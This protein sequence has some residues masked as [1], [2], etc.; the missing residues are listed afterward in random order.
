M[1][2]SLKSAKLEL[3]VKDFSNETH[4]STFPPGLNFAFQYYFNNVFEVQQNELSS[5]AYEITIKVKVPGKDDGLFITGNQLSL[6]NWNPSQI[7]M[8]KK[9][10]FE[11]EL[12]VKVHSPAQFKFTKGDW[13]TEAAVKNGSMQNITIIPEDNKEYHFEI[14]GFNQ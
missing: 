4:W 6:G 2:D 13:E 9:S 14:T 12:K 11:R 3:V 8:N 10:D 5:E 7:K 1:N